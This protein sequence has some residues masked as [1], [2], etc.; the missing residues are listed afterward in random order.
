MPLEEGLEGWRSVLTRGECKSS[1]RWKEFIDSGDWIQVPPNI[2]E[3]VY[4]CL[5]GNFQDNMQVTCNRIVHRMVVNNHLQHVSKGH[6]RSFFLNAIFHE[7]AGED[8]IFTNE[9]KAGRLRRLIGK[10]WWQ[11]TGSQ[12]R[13]YHE[14]ELQD[15]W[16]NAVVDIDDILLSLKGQVDIMVGGGRV[17]L[18]LSSILP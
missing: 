14:M 6:I 13:D 1:R 17:D 8:R 11:V 10:K 4:F 18:R 2:E 15:A 7:L 5:A 12:S 9:R 3:Y 16:D